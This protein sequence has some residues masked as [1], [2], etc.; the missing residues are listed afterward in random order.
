VVDGVNG[1]TLQL[2]ATGKDFADAIKRDLH[3]GM[4]RQMRE[5]ALRLA[6][7]KLSWEVWSEKFRVLC[8]ALPRT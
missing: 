2:G 4:L 8:E 6:H 5:G 3:D 1:R 7:E